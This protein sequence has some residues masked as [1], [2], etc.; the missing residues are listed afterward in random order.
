MPDL[1]LE[2]QH[3]R[4]R[5]LGWSPRCDVIV[6]G[7]DHG[8]DLSLAIGTDGRV[9]LAASEGM[10]NLAQGL[11][12]SLTTARGSDIFNT[13][14]G[15]DGLTAM[16]EETNAMLVRE[17]IRVSVV[18]VLRRDPRIRRIVE[19]T[20]PAGTIDPALPLADQIQQ[21]R[22]Y[23]IRVAFETITAERAALDLGSVI[24]DA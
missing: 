21:W 19:V 13:A 24:G 2:R 14:F 10:D 11:G 23:Q 20:V 16:V 18:D 4:R 22:T 7:L 6:P 1:E 12:V 5:L 15:F 17:R 9:D 3:I 8:R